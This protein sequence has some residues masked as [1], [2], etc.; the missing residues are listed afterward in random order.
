MTAFGRSVNGEKQILRY[1]QDDR[2]GVGRVWAEA[3][4]GR[5]GAGRNSNA[6]GLPDKRRRGAENAEARRYKVEK[7]PQ[8]RPGRKLRAR[9]TFTAFQCSPA[10]QEQEGTNAIDQLRARLARFG[11]RKIGG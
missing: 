10:L 5:L 7:V 6:A 8:I 2:R 3:G 1:A 4:G 9:C 11:G